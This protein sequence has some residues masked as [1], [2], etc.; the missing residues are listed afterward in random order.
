MA[1]LENCIQQC[2]DFV[3]PIFKLIAENSPNVIS[4]ALNADSF[5]SELLEFHWEPLLESDI[6]KSDNLIDLTLKRAVYDLLNSEDDRDDL[7]MRIKKCSVVLDF[8]FHS[9]QFREQPALWIV[10][11]FELFST[12]VDMLNWPT[13]TLQ[14]WPYVESRMDWFKMGNN[15]KPLPFGATNMISYKQPLYDKLRH[16]NDLLKMVQ[17]NSSLNTPLD[18]IMS[19]KLNKFLSELLPLHEESNFNRSALISTKQGSGNPWNKTISSATKRDSSSE[20]V[21]ATDYNYIFDNLLTCPLEFTFRPTEHK[22]DL[23]KVL[24]NLLDSIFEIEED[25]YKKIRNSHKKLVDINEKLNYQYPCE[26]DYTPNNQPVYLKNSSRIIQKRESFWN[27]LCSL[28]SSSIDMLQPTLLDISTANPDTLYN[29]MMETDND[30]YRKQFLMQLYFTINMV[31]QII[32]LPEVEKFY[33]LCYQKEKPSR[34]INFDK[35]DEPNRRKTSALCNHILDSRVIKFYRYRDPPFMSL[36]QRL[37]IKD[38][39]FLEAKVDGFKIFQNFQVS[40]QSLEPLTFDYTFKKFGFIEMGNKLINNVW[41]VNTG[42]DKIKKPE[43]SVKELYD[44][45]YEKFSSDGSVTSIAEY[46]D[47]V[48]REWQQLRSLRSQYLFEFSKVDENVG[49]HG[50]FNSSLVESQKDKKKE[51]FQNILQETRRPHISKL[52][53]ARNYI[54]EKQR[55]KR[56][57]TEETDENSHKRTKIGTPSEDSAQENTRDDGKLTS[58]PEKSKESNVPMPYEGGV[59]STTPEYDSEKSRGSTVT[60]ENMDRG[61]EQ[62][63]END[64]ELKQS[65]EQEKIQ[66]MAHQENQE[67]FHGQKQN[68]QGEDQEPDQDQTQKQEENSGKSAEELLGQSVRSSSQNIESS[69]LQATDDER[70]RAEPNQDLQ[71]GKQLK[72]MNADISTTEIPENEHLVPPQL[73]DNNIGQEGDSQQP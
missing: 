23:D 42:L 58:G 14:F 73:E 54:A 17:N 56:V 36:L 32:T 10:P 43:E 65:Q 6:G 53:E 11:Y 13:S 55:R 52:E 8:C 21:F 38:K 35:L 69:Q 12:A 41:K 27:K 4:S 45:F 71:D 46:D 31:R 66:E 15:L 40:E 7:T 72:E 70:S 63:Q 16:W 68:Q 24:A 60:A 51:L 47:K 3:L 64:P 49:I 50:L 20:N 33:K 26:Y 1:L 19:Y 22:M 5:E 57:H 39:L 59:L 62:D 2:V 30:F 37:A 9:K 67:P 25:F 29:Q 34:S 48:I 61:K 44:S 18:N 28:K